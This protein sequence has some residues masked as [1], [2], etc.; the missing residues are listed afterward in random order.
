[1]FHDIATCFGRRT[2][3]FSKHVEC[4]KMVPA[5][6]IAHLIPRVDKEEELPTYVNAFRRFE[7]TSSTVDCKLVDQLQVQNAKSLN[8]RSKQYTHEFYYLIS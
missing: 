3:H 2:G 4:R 8:H 7:V 1:M 5:T 6:A